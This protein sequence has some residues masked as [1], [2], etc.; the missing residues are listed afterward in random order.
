MFF[1]DSSR[2]LCVCVSVC[3]CCSFAF[4]FW[5]DAFL[6]EWKT[7][8]KLHKKLIGAC[9]DWM[10]FCMQCLMSKTRLEIFE[11]ETRRF[12]FCIRRMCDSHEHS[13]PDFK[14]ISL[15]VTEDFYLFVGRIRSACDGKNEGRGST[16]VPKIELHALPQRTT[17]L[18]SKYLEVHTN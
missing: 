6:T 16:M 15:T 7:N 14:W 18:K 10:P 5:T 12:S 8:S 13:P 17:V 3:K 9:F 1:P 11:A 4:C 2:F